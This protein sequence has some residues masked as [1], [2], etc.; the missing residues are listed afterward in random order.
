MQEGRT[1][2]SNESRPSGSSFQPPSAPALQIETPAPP[3][4]HPVPPQRLIGKGSK[5]INCSNFPFSFKQNLILMKCIFSYLLC[6][7]GIDDLNKMIKF[8]S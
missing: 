4:R 7:I 1:L 8:G 6:R 3:P 5:V 2:T